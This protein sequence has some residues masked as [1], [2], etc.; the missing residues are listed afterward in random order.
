MNLV[1]VPSSQL[2]M[3]MRVAPGDP[4]NSYLIMKHAG[5][6]RIVN[7]RMPLNNPTFFTDNPQLL[8][9][10]RTWVMEGAQNN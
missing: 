3:F 5:D 4:M 9:L 10:E 1:G 2:P 6:E 7:G 8:D